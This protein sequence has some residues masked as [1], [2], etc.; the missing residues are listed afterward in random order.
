MGEQ[1]PEDERQ[2][3]SVATAGE[4][5]DQPV[6]GS[7]D[8][9]LRYTDIAAAV[10]LAIATVATAWCA[11]QSTRWSGVQATAF[12]EASTN[13]VESTRQFNLAVQLLSIDA[14]LFVQWVNAYAEGNDELLAFYENNLMRPQFLPYLEEWVASRPRENPDALRNPLI[15]ETYQQELLAESERL[16]IVAEGRFKDATSANQTADDYVLATVLF[17][18]VL[19]F[20]GISSKFERVRIQAALVVLAFLMVVF[21][22]IQFGSLPIE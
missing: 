9:A 17:A 14:G 10:L 21:G 1:P 20:A 2:Q 16:R 5:H 4:S 18:S 6:Q 8:R 7:V 15:N 11:Y 22:A 19:F 3:R 12:A 13:R